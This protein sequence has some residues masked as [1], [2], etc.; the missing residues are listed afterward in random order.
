ME[1]HAKIRMDILVEAPLRTR[2]SALLD[3]FGVSGYTIFSAL[4]GRGSAGLWIRAGL[5]TDVGQMLL[6][7][8]ILDPDRREALLETIFERYA[9][10][11]GYVTI[12]PVEV[13]RPQ[14][15]P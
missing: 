7:V 2:F 13:V 10:Q 1:T 8:C 5:V 11:I 9:D 3:Q 15:F 6:F 4:G 14:K 12:S